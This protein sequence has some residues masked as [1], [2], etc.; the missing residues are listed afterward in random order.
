MT[1]PS[2]NEQKNERQNSNASEKSKEL[3]P[4]AQRQRFAAHL[5]LPQRHKNAE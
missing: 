2:D 5:L 1:R 3:H 4:Y